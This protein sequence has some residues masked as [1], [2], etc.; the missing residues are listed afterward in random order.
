M[1][2]RSLEFAVVRAGAVMSDSHDS[3]QRAPPPAGRPKA[4]QTLAEPKL[5]GS[6]KNLILNRRFK[7]ML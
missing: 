2:L 6:G 5:F 4:G 7:S 3:K 1:N